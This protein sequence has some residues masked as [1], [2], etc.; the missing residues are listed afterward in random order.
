M[1]PVGMAVAVVENGQI[2]LPSGYGRIASDQ[3]KGIDADTV[4]PLHSMSK[5]FVSAALAVLVDEG[6]I[7]WSDPVIQYIPEFATRDPYVTKNLTVCDLL[8]HNP[9]LALGAGDLLSWPDQTAPTAETIAALRYLPL[10][11]GF[12]ASTSPK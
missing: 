9:G 11:T 3:E 6:K 5:S 8:V 12:R 7:S 10:D 4:F 2:S 1:A